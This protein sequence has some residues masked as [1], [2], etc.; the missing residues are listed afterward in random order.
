MKRVSQILVASAMCALFGCADHS[1]QLT[2]D[3]S[4]DYGNYIETLVPNGT[5][6]QSAIAIMTDKGFSH[7]YSTNVTYCWWERFEYDGVTSNSGTYIG[8]HTDIVDWVICER[9]NVTTE[10][11]HTNLNPTFFIEEGKVTDVRI[12]IHRGKTD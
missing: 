3:A 5:P 2:G 7:T 8:A 11:P 6:I 9:T 12:T 1:V 10:F 4:T